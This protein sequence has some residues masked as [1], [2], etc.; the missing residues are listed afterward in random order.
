[1]NSKSRNRPKQE[2]NLGQVWRRPLA[3]VFIPTLDEHFSISTRQILPKLSASLEKRGSCRGAKKFRN[4][5]REFRENRGQSTPRSKNSTHHNS[6]KWGAI[7]PNKILFLLG[8]PAQSRPTTRKYSVGVHQLRTNISRVPLVRF[9][10][11]FQVPQGSGAPVEGRK[12][13]EI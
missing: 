2:I 11:N 6:P 13:S 12:N 5:T 10:P 3:S 1:M 9:R 7:P 8:S 4:L